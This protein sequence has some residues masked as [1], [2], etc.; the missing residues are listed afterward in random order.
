MTRIVTCLLVGLLL[1]ITENS[2]FP[3]S[4]DDNLTS[5]SPTVQNFEIDFM[6][7]GV[8]CAAIILLVLAFACGTFFLG[9]G[10]LSCGFSIN[11]YEPI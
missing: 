5:P 2:G 1:A 10:H 4:F 6:V 7:L 3:Q 11:R 9:C 8:I